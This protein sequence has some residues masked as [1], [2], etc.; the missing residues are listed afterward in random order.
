LV[1]AVRTPSTTV[2][3][4][5]PKR[6]EGS[7]A[8]ETLKWIDSPDRSM[9]ISQE[10]D[11]PMVIRAASE[12]QAS[13]PVMDRTVAVR[14]QRSPATVGPGAG[15]G[16]AIGADGDGDVMALCPP[17]ADATIRSRTTHKARFLDIRLIVSSSFNFS[18][19]RRA[20]CACSGL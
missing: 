11:C 2:P 5:S 16:A 3:S 1:A 6:S 9:V 12:M 8:S 14:F 13:G 7:S 20:R 19:A 18:Q 10:T 4:Y 15:D 17:H